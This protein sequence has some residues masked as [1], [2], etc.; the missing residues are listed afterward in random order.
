MKMYDLIM[1]K[2]DGGRHT[3][4]EINYIVSGYA[5]GDIPDYQMSAWLMS[6]FFSGMDDEESAELTLAMAESGDMMDLSPIRGAKVDKHS[7][8]GVGDKTTLA[9]GPMVASCGLKVGKMSGRGLGHTGGTLDKLEAIPGFEINISPEEFFDIVNS[10]GLA[11]VGQTGNLAPADKKL[12]A[13]RDV[14]ATVDSIPLIAASIMSKK[15]AAGNDGI[16]LDVKCGKG[17]FMHDL[18]S[19]QK[20][21]SLMVNI[22]KIRGRKMAAV[23]SAMD[24]PLG[25]KVG[26]ALEVEEAIDTLKGNG[27]EDF[28]TLCIRLGREMLRLGGIG[29]NDSDRE[30]MLRTNLHNG[31]ALKR[32]RDMI[33]AQ[34][35]DPGVIE[36]YN[37][38]GQASEKIPLKADRSGYITGIDA[39]MTGN[40]AML[41]GAGREKKEDDIDMNVGIEFIV[42]SG[43]RVNEGDDI[44]MLH[45]NSRERLAEAEN[46]MRKAVVIDNVRPESSDLIYEVIG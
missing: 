2:R 24:Q 36:D 28:E 12:Y 35:G 13:L 20:L 22:G 29:E 19:A 41:L 34:H 23:I 37:I 25:L 44:L 26:N 14:T 11:V 15:L 9:L 30:E 3:K 16:V 10:T 33:E 21:A 8:G 17:A 43:E 40:A 38:M 1:K 45:V 6:I 32:F 46:I 27:P 5:A 42:K 4:E 7:S 39:L 31:E 18:K